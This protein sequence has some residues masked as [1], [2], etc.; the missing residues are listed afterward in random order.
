MTSLRTR[1]PALLALAAS[2][3]AGSVALAEPAPPIGPPP[4]PAAAPAP[5]LPA[6]AAALAAD[7]KPAPAPNWLRK[8]A[9]PAAPALGTK[10]GPSPLRIGGMLALVATLGGIAYYARRRKQ[11]AP[12]AATKKEQ[13]RV[14][15]STRIGPK[16]TAVVVEIAGKRIL[17]GV[18][19]HSVNNLAWLDDE[20]NQ[21]VEDEVSSLRS[22]SAARPS[23]APE[24]A[25]PSGF[26]KLLRS[27]VGSGTAQKLV[28][29]D[30][31]ARTTRDEVR[32]SRRDGARR[33][34]RPAVE[35]DDDLLEGQVMGLVKRRKEQP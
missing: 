31:V 32:I 6:I 18:T 2:V 11:A 25:G 29:S 34:Q 9:K 23:Q 24:N 21:A 17:L 5:S 10:Q 4:A 1:S 35:H 3:L 12:A 22:A 28:A 13:P 20:Q 16:A 27:A 15:G 7:K 19:E 30:E 8:P 33:E 26:L 14:L